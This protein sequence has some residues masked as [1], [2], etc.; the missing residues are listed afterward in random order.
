MERRLLGIA[1]GAGLLLLATPCGAGDRLDPIAEPQ[2]TGFYL[3]GQ[4]GGAWSKSAWDY[5]N[6]NW[7]NTLGPE[8]VISSFDIDANGF[9]GGGQTGFNF[10]SGAW[11]FGVEGSVAGTELDGHIRSPFFPDDDSYGVDVGWLAAVTGRIGY[12]W[13]RWLTYG[14][15]GWAGADIE[16]DL[17]DQVTP[18]RAKSNIWA[19]GYTLGGGAEYDLRN[20]FSLAVD[21]AYIDL[22]TNRLT[23]RCPTCPSGIGGGVPA[24]D[25]DLEIQSVTARINYRFGN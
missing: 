11:I 10:Q 1:V 23:L 5:K 9:V 15:G 3:G 24:V 8:L 22:D 2:W 4:L 25:G 18:V 16:L 6:S 20:G 19:N 14:K 7:F 17:F 12:A 21:Y 13:G